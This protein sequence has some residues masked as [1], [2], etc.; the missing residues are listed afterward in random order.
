MLK[1]CDA[2]GA[3]RFNIPKRSQ[4]QTEINKIHAEITEKTNF[5][6]QAKNSIKDFIR[7]K[8]G[9]EGCPAKYELYRLYFKKEKYIYTNLSRCILRGN[10]ID[11]EVWIPEDH[12]D[13]K[14]KTLKKFM[15]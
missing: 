13:V 1:I 8:V 5:L 15:K 4:I 10:F 6:K 2:F 9:N 12:Y 3:S 11:G 7:D 14:L